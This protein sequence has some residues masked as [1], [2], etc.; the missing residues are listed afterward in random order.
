MKIKCGGTEI[1][2]LDADAHLFG[3]DEP[4]ME[5]HWRPEP[6]QICFDVGSGP[7]A[8]TLA[9]LARG[10]FTFSFDPRPVAVR[11]LTDNIFANKFTKGIVLPF[12][13]WN[14]Q[15]TLP[16]GDA[17]FVEG[18][19]RAPMRHAYPA[20]TL[21]EFMKIGIN[22]LD[23]MT[24]DAE[25]AELEIL[26]GGRETIQKFKPKIIIELHS[27]V[28]VDSVKDELRGYLF[29]DESIPIETYHCPEYPIK[30]VSEKPFACRFLIATRR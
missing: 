1:E 6:G 16:F 14:K 20:T 27:G 12:G 22:R 19:E 7:G 15:D 18:F 2:V 24:I 28:N 17:S 29:Q 8:W 3:F 9:A 30:F 4:I 21:D 11:I 10:A 26:T 5:K 25:A 23:L 13:L